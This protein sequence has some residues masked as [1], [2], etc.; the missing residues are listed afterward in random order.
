MRRVKTKF[1]YAIWFAAGSKL[2]GSWSP[3]SFEAASVMGFGFN[4]KQA[5]R[6]ATVAL[7]VGVKQARSKRGCIAQPCHDQKFC[8]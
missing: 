8:V 7:A 6:V 2:V 4:C 1:H 3:T 5:N